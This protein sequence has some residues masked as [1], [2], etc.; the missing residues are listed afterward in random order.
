MDNIYFF[1]KKDLLKNGQIDAKPFL[2]DKHDISHL[3]SDQFQEYL[4]F[5]FSKN[6]EK[7]KLI[8]ETVNKYF[9]KNDIKPLIN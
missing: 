9:K 3:I 5:I 8:S 6:K 2:V 4:F 7:R 1:S